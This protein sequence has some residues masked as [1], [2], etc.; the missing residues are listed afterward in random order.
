MTIENLPLGAGLVFT[1]FYPC[2]NLKHPGSISIEK[3][4]VKGGEPI[5]QDHMR[6]MAELDTNPGLWALKPLTFTICSTN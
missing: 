6:G 2:F 1:F 4:G 5:A 3:E